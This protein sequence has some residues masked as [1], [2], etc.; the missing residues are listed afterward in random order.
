MGVYDPTIHRREDSVWFQ[1]T[2][3]VFYG[4]KENRGREFEND[5]EGVDSLMQNIVLFAK[6]VAQIKADYR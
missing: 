2:K 3:R 6:E 1:S 5:A 4:K